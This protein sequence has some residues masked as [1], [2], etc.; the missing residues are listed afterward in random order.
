MKLGDRIEVACYGH[1]HIDS[2]LAVFV[3]GKFW[4]LNVNDCELGEGDAAVIREKW[5]RSYCVV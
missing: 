3:S 2:A 4:L 5:G 1:R